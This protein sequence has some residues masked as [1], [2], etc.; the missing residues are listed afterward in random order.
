[1]SLHHA[2]KKVVLEPEVVGLTTYPELV[3]ALGDLMV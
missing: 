1:M 2:V 3:T